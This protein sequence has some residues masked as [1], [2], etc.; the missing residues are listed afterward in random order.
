[1]SDQWSTHS[2]GIDGP[3]NNAAVVTPNNSTDLTYA[4]RALVVGVAGTI[5]VD[6]VGIGTNIELTVEAGVLPIRV[7]RV[8]ATGTTATNIV[9]LW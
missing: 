5:T 9:A 7:T 6:M 2:T 3:A 4:S 1:M 8:Y